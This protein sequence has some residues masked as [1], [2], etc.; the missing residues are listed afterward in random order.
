MASRLAAPERKLSLSKTNSVVAQ[1]AWNI[2]GYY[3]KQ[4]KIGL[5]HGDKTGHVVVHCNNSVMAIDFGVREAKTYSLLLDQ[6]LCEI[7]ID[8][9]AGEGFTY[10]CRINHEADTPLNVERRARRAEEQRS[11]R[12]RLGAALAFIVTIVA[13]LIL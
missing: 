9:A 10:D 4:Y 5:F 11:E 7:S 8:P 3:G 6:Q 13:L 12:W 1:H 2:T